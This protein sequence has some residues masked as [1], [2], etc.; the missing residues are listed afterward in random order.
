MAAAGSKANPFGVC[1]LSL[2]PAV[3]PV[4]TRSGHVYSREALLE[5]MLL[6]TDELKRMRAQAKKD[7]QALE[8]QQEADRLALE[9][10]GFIKVFEQRETT[11]VVGDASKSSSNASGNKPSNPSRFTARGIGDSG[12]VD[13]HAAPMLLDPI[14]KYPGS[15]VSG[16]PL[17]LKHMFPIELETEKE[18]SSGCVCSVSRRRLINQPVVAIIK[19]K[20]VMLKEVYEKLALPTLTCPV[21]GL[22]FDPDIDVIELVW[23]SAQPSTKRA[24]VS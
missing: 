21:T 23:A 14:P 9:R 18:D 5:Y 22:T 13:Y 7:K 15:P 12:V 4:V 10:E 17:Q 3:D 8:E 20:K 16:R 11:G 1:C 2:V 6:K 24:K 19:S